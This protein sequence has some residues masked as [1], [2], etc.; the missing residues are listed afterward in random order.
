MAHP[1]AHAVQVRA[2]VHALRM[3][4]QR[5]DAGLGR[6][7]I[8]AGD[9]DRAGVAQAIGHRRGEELEFAGHHRGARGDA[10]LREMDMVAAL[11]FERHM[12]TEPGRQPRREHAGRQHDPVDRKRATGRGQRIDPAIGHLQ[13]GDVTLQVIAPG[14]DEMVEQPAGQPQR[15]RD[16]ALFGQQHAAHVDRRQVGVVLTDLRR[17]EFDHLHTAVAPQLPCKRIGPVGSFGLVHRDVA[18]LVDQ[19]GTASRVRQ[20][21]VCLEGLPE[22]RTQCVG[23]LLDSLAP[24]RADEAPQPGRRLRQVA[25]LD[26]QR[27]SRVGEPLGHLPE[28]PRH[29][30]R[31]HRTRAQDAGIAHRR[32]LARGAAIDQRHRMAV[33]LQVARHRDADDARADHRDAWRAQ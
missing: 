30:D 29:A 23:D 7:R 22:Q 11:R 8:E 19:V 33:A 10:G 17:V 13:A 9:L 27:R 16:M 20:R 28:N 24:A 25:P 32:E 31:H 14:R 21:A 5:V 3:A 26:R 12:R 4:H 18:R 15:I 6:R 1:G 2:R